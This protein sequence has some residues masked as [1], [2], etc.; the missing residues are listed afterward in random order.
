[1]MHP[2][3]NIVKGSACE[4]RERGEAPHNCTP[5]VS[6]CGLL[7]SMIGR[8]ATKP[9]ASIST[10]FDQSNFLCDYFDRYV[11]NICAI[12]PFKKKV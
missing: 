4:Q 7:I 3:C 10:W 2:V 8:Y 11:F 12:V 1:M 9:T 6:L 5:E